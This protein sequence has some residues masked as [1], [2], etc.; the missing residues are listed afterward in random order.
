VTPEQDRQDVD[1]VLA[2]E[3]EAFTGIVE[4]WQGPLVQLAYRFSGDRGSAEEMAQDAFVKVYRQLA[5]W[6]GEGA[7]STWLFA[8][9]LN[10]YRSWLR[11]RRPLALPI[12]EVTEP[13]ADSDVAGEYEGVEAARRIRAEV[14][15]LP[16][17]YRD[18][19]T[20]FYF[21]EMSVESAA[22]SLD[23]PQ[24]TLKSLLH[25]GRKLL[26]ERLRGISEPLVKEV[27]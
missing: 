10:V 8:V 19:L 1:R 3:I 21:H 17:R 27:G 20:L 16:E 13:A 2:G 25:R 26:E 12:E 18:A 14:R 9:S 23:I 11:K 5:K 24:G 22:A 4:R 6:R 15:G 7:F